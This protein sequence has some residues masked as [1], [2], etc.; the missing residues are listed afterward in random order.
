MNRNRKEA[1]LKLKLAA[2]WLIIMATIMAELLTY[3]WSRVQCVTI[4]YEITQASRVL[5]QQ[6]AVGKA[7]EI[8][9]A[10]LTSPSRVVL[11]AQEIL[12]LVRPRPE[13]V[14]TL[15]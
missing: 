11:Q 7:M 3:T 9:Y 2:A 10:L 14:I 5:E 12:A 1:L 4:G 8:E 13:Q 6:M 15:R